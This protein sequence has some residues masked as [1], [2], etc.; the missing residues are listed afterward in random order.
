[1]KN[2]VESF[3]FEG[4]FLGNH[5]KLKF[6]AN[7]RKNFAHFAFSSDKSM[8]RKIS[9]LNRSFRY[10]LLLNISS[11]LMSSI[12]NLSLQDDI[13]FRITLK[14]FFVFP[15]SFAMIGKIK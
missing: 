4:L 6:I 9:E 15:L 1:L 8:R 12:L 10:F 11:K 5:Y 13:K 7:L 14:H 3:V 2:L